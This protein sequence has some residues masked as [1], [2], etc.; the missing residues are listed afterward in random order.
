[1]LADRRMYEEKRSKP[2]LDRAMNPKRDSV[3]NDLQG[4]SIQL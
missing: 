4:Q 1:M 3:N 2:M